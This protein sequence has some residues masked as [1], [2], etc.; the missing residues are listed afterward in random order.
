M[1]ESIEINIGPKLARQ[2]ADGQA[3]RTEC[4][5]QIVAG[6]RN[7]V[8]SFA[9]HALAAGE[10]QID[11]PHHLKVAD[12]TR[13]RGVQNGVID[14]G[15][16][17]AQIKW[18]GKFVPPRKFL[19]AIQR[20]VR[21]FTDAVGVRVEDKTALEDRR[22]D[23]AQRVMHDAVAEIGGADEAALGFVDVKT[24]VFPRAIRFDAQFFL[25]AQ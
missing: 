11:E 9:Q 17:L 21:A 1:I 22:D 7:H 15:K 20:T 23:I 8:V 14:A 16:E 6:E 25:Q 4:R 2:I 24:V 13:Q 5:E 19:A 3:T 18:H 12:F 10:N